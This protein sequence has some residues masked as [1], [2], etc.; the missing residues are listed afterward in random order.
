MPSLPGPIAY[1]GLQSFGGY[2]YVI[3]GD[4]GTISPQDGPDAQGQSRSDKVLYARINL[5]NGELMNGWSENSGSLGK[6]RS[7]HSALVAGGSMFVSAGLY[8]AAKTGSSENTYAQMNSDGSVGSFGGATGSNT[9]LSI[10]AGNLFNHA[11]LSYV[12]GDGV[13]HVMILGGDDVND[14]G[15]RSAKVFYY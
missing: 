15:L 10:G 12:D 11:A 3:G 8:S 13:A 6:T 4:A 9:L 1:H 7:K 14:P 5:R 2:L